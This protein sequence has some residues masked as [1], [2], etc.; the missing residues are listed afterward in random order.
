MLLSDGT[1]DLSVKPS[2][3]VFTEKDETSF[4]QCT[5]GSGGA[6]FRVMTVRGK[7]TGAVTTSTIA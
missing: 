5:D 2:N 4:S 6:A 1:G 7:G 3:V